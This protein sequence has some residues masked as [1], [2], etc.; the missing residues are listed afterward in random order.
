M[1]KL[2]SVF[3]PSEC[4]PGDE[5]YESARQLGSH[6]ARAHFLVITGSYEG[7]M[8]AA[9]RGAVEAGGKTIGVAAEVYHA[10]GRS[11]NPYILKEVRVKSAVDQLM[12]LLDLADAYVAIGSSPGTLLEVVTAWDFT[13][14]GFLPRKPLLLVGNGWRELHNIFT[15]SAYFESYREHLTYASQPEDAIAHLE[16]TFGRQQNLPYLD[17]L[18]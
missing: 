15:T 3:G 12:E 2:V 8:E 10:R 9:A 11:V 4:Q 18:S 17:V 14:K 16:Q 7:V 6:L 1:K 5:L 13:K